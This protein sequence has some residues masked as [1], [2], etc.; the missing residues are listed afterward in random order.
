MEKHQVDE[1]KPANTDHQSN[2]HSNDGSKG[3]LSAPAEK[4]PKAGKNETELPGMDDDEKESDEVIKSGLGDEDE[5]ETD[6]ESPSGNPMNRKP[7]NTKHGDSD[8][9][10]VTNRKENEVV[11]K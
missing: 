8:G 11:N 10:P 5:H 9:A 2:Q 1:R 7:E 3:K 4:D 6:E